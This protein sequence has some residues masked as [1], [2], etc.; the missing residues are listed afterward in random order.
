MSKIENVIMIITKFNLYDNFPC[1]SKLEIYGK[2][3]LFGSFFLQDM[4]YY[5]LISVLF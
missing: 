3:S 4:R 2:G 1:T 5:K